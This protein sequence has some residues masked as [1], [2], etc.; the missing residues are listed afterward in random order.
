MELLALAVSS[1][2]RG[3]AFS[4]AF[5]VA[6]PASVAIDM[7]G[8]SQVSVKLLLSGLTEEVLLILVLVLLVAQ[9][10]SSGEDKTFKKTRLNLFY[11]LRLDYPYRLSRCQGQSSCCSSRRIDQRRR[12]QKKQDG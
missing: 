9:V 5:T 1:G 10:V 8:I 12:R 3:V 2:T 11:C 6:C 4:I 7:V